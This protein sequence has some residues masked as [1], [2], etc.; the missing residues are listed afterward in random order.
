[1]NPKQRHEHNNSGHRET[2]FDKRYMANMRASIHRLMTRQG[3]PV[4]NEQTIN[5]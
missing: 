2:K 5:Q 4:N 1:M 3:T